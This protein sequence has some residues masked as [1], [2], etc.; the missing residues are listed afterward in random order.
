LGGPIPGHVPDHRWDDP[1]RGADPTRSRRV[2]HA[3]VNK[4]QDPGSDHHDTIR[5]GGGSSMDKSRVVGLLLVAHVTAALASTNA[6]SAPK[7]ESDRADKEYASE[8]PYTPP[9]SPEES[10]KA[11]RLRPGFRIELAAAEPLLASPV[12]L[13]FDEDG[14]VYVAEFREFN[15]VASNRPHGRGRVRLLEDADGDGVFDRS[16][17]FLDDVDSPTA[18]C[19]YD[20]GAF[21]GAV[22][23]IL[24]AKDTDG[25]GHADV[26]RVVFTGFARDVGGEAMLNSFR[27][28]LDNRIHVQTS[29]SGGAVRHAENKDARPVS[30][31]GQGFLFDPRTEAFELA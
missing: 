7:P 15:Q 22:P 13:D 23:D 31:R 30:V 6:E 27:W 17:V 5:A 8:L 25:D 29:Y 11:F 10:L 9:K 26:R 24:Y 1:D 12:A 3:A 16:T 4:A 20:G 21:V 19:C 28:G 18:L 14:R 2:V